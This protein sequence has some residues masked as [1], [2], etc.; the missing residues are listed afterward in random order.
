MK[1]SILLGLM[2]TGVYCANAQS[3]V[4]GRDHQPVDT[5]YV[6]RVYPDP[7]KKPYTWGVGLKYTPGAISAKWYSKSGDALEVLMSAFDHGSRGTVLLE[8]SPGLSTNG[9]FRLLVGPGLHLG[10]IKRQYLSNSAANPVFGVDGIGGFEFTAPKMH[11]TFQLDYQPSL[12]FNGNDD[13]YLN[14]GGLTIRYVW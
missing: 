8:I 11:L 3:V 4:L 10:V 13:T 2:A 7:N 12:D 5:N 1:K 9:N 14:W 6:A